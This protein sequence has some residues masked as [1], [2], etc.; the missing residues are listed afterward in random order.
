MLSPSNAP[1]VCRKQL[2]SL[3]VESVAYAAFGGKIRGLLV[4]PVQREGCIEKT[5]VVCMDNR[6]S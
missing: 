2:S 3:V 1:Q 5:N 6:G 4:V